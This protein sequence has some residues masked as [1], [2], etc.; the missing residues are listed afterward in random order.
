MQRTAGEF[1]LYCVSCIG[2]V[3][4]AESFQRGIPD[5]SPIMFWAYYL[6]TQIQT[7]KSHIL[8]FFVE[9]IS[10]NL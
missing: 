9:K 8:L 4:G 3:K 6:Q 2:K 7:P 5:T 1:L 10:H